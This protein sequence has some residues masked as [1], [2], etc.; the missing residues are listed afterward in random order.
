MKQL[1]YAIIFFSLL[2]CI[3][4]TSTPSTDN[5]ADTTALPADIDT[6]C[7]SDSNRL[8]LS[9]MQADSLI[10]R[11]THHYSLNYNFIVKSDSLTLVPKENDL[12]RDTCRI[13]K[14]D[15]IAVA[16]IK[17]GA[18]DS[19]DTIWIKVARD[20]FTMGWVPE[21]ELLLSTTPDNTISQ[22]IDFLSGS[23]VIW[24]SCL[25]LLGIAAIIINRRRQ[26]A[27][28]IIANPIAFLSDID[29]PYPAVFLTL[30]AL[31]ACLYASIQNFVPEY[32]QE[33]YFHPTLNP[34]VL[35]PVMAI[36]VT[37]VWT[38]ITTYIAVIDEVYHNFYFAPGATFLMKLTGLAMIIYLVVSWSTLIYIGYALLIF[39]T[40][41]IW[42]RQRKK[43]EISQ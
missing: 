24:M 3:G 15:V 38:L 41:W 33:Y 26:K 25:S 43:A 4:S 10:F 11:L 12:I 5:K 40:V 1:L 20:Q 34:L 27:D 16:D 32:W 35:P 6:V 14:E 31:L 8:N 29:S 30:T 23:R 22:L 28:S 39:L 18:R 21:Q 37:I 42:R 17:F 36:L 2:S 7:A 13:Y 9:Q 19:V